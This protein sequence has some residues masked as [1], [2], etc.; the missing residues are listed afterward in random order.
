[1]PDFEWDPEKEALNIR[2]HGIDF[3]TAQLIWE[4]RVLER[5]DD[6]REYGEVRFQA[7][8][9]VDNRI[10]TVIFTWRGETRRIIS[11]RRANLREKRFFEAEIPEFGRPPPD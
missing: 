3:T 7:F 5:V 1:M 2:K 10:L 4:G 6:R 9:V 11:A 8:G